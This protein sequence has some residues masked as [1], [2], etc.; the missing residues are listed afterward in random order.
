[1]PQSNKL[2]LS[3]AIFINLNIMVS[4]GIFVNTVILSQTSGAA[5]F[6]LYPLI[7]ILMLPLIAAIGTLL[8]EYPS[9]GFYAFAKDI[10]PFLGFLSCWSYF[11]AK[12]ASGSLMLYVATVFFQQLI[13][14]LATIDPVLI[15]LLTLIV[16]A[17]FNLLNTQIG[18]IIQGFFL[19]AKFIP[20]LFVIFSGII[21]LDT[22]G[23]TYDSFIWEGVSISVPLV[24]YC[25]AGFEAACSLSRNIENP[26]VN[27]PKAIYYSFSIII[28]LY[29]LFQGLIYLGTHTSLETLATYKD[30]FPFL[31]H[32]FF[33]SEILAN[34][35]A[36]LMAFT[37][38][39]SALGGSYGVLF[40]NS[41]NLYTLA[42]NGHTFM[43]KAVTKLNR[44]NMPMFAIFLETAVCALFLLLTRGY[45]VPLQQTA[46]FGVTLAY[47]ISAFAY[48]HFIKKTATSWVSFIIPSFA[49]ITCAIFILSCVNSFMQTGII[50]LL[51]F[52]AILIFGTSMFVYQE[53]SKTS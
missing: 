18:V 25:L 14:Q 32:K 43:P 20:I 35:I 29:G 52:I 37:I 23:I 31:A 36:T 42:E 38:G 50:P 45:Q 19:T 2:S 46:S 15:S 26:S 39:S 48:Y 27:A 21:M 7:G 44:H 51:L 24:L 47:S 33:S 34:K 8:K 28:V 11:F 40:S 12:L 41:W 5:C 9:G 22:S 17:F 3:S 4:T 13:P 30:T 10:S 6:L 49:F 16:F 1:M 53:Q